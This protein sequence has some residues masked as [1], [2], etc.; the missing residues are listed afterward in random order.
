MEISCRD[1]CRQ[2]VQS[3][4]LASVLAGSSV[5]DYCVQVRATGNTT[6]TAA[7]GGTG[8]GSQ[9]TLLLLAAVTLCGAIVGQATEIHV[10][11]EAT[12]TDSRASLQL[13]GGG[14]RG[15]DGRCVFVLLLLLFCC[16]CC[17]CCV[18]VV[19]V[20]CCVSRCVATF[21]VPR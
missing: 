4:R 15:R 13:V 16:C 5:L 20:C 9:T 19:V 3:P 8:G 2:A 21:P 14:G 17:C 6:T 12:Q 10:K 11:D 1:R 18:V 7:A